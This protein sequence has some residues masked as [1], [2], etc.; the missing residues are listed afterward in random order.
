MKTAYLV[1]TILGAVGPYWFFVPWLAENG[2]DLPALVSELFSTRVGAFFGLDVVISSLVVFAFIFAERQH[3]RVA[4]LWAS[5]VGTLVI[6]VSCGLPLYLYLREVSA[7]KD[8]A[9]A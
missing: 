2:L 6:G 5:I 8:R 7:T 1:L 3:R 9:A 4:H